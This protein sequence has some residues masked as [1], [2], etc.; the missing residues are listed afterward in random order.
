VSLTKDSGLAG[1]IFLIKQHTGRELP[2]DDPGLRAIHEKV[3]HEFE[4]GRQTSIEWE[5][6]EP[7]VADL[8]QPVG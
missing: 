1:L 5:E 3:T 2:K 6:L 7:L 8:L 4:A